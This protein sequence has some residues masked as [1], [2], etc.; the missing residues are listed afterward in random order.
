MRGPAPAGA[1]LVQLDMFASVGEPCGISAIA[2]VACIHNTDRHTRLT[3]VLF[4]AFDLLGP[5]RAAP[6]NIDMQM[7]E[8]ASSVV[9]DTINPS[10]IGGGI[11]RIAQ[12]LGITNNRGRELL[13][14]FLDEPGKLL[15]HSFGRPAAC[16]RACEEMTEIIGFIHVDIIDGAAGIGDSADD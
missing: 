1:E 5:R 6:I 8:L 15:R 2:M 12:W 14:Y 13:V 16:L 3:A 4:D 7:T 11:H 10:S 9:P